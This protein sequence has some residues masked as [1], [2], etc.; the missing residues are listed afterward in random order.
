M[1]LEGILASIPEFLTCFLVSMEG[2]CGW[3]RVEDFSP[4][5]QLKFLQS[6][7]RP[8]SK[9]LFDSVSGA[10]LRIFGDLSRLQKRT[11]K[12]PAERQNHSADASAQAPCYLAAWVDWGLVRVRTADTVGAGEYA[13]TVHCA[14]AT[15]A[16]AGKGSCKPR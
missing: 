1:I 4:A 10:A 7:A 11:G 14:A 16:E 13:D 12:R 5:Q 15:Q 9:F 8:A 2:L 3:G 6:L